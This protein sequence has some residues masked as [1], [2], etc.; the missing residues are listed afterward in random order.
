MNYNYIPRSA[1]RLTM[2]GCFQKT[3]IIIVLSFLVLSGIGAASNETL[4]VDLPGFAFSRIIYTEGYPKDLYE[5]SDSFATSMGLGWYHMLNDRMGLGPNLVFAPLPNDLWQS[6]GSIKA[7]ADFLWRIKTVNVGIPVDI[8]LQAGVGLFGV[9]VVGDAHPRMGG[10]AGV[11]PLARLAL[12]LET[13]IRDD[14][15]G[16]I[17]LRLY[18]SADDSIQKGTNVFS[19]TAGFGIT[20][21]DVLGEKWEVKE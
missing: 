3:L 6:Y 12:A 17:N 7:T 8:C 2:F 14:N 10:P 9:A 1:T 21:L 15:P 16:N 18:V 19:I 5:H 4:V 11:Y 13:E 20:L